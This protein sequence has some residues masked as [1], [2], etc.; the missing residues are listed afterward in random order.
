MAA[1]ADTYKTA[2]LLCLVPWQGCWE[3]GST[4][5]LPLSLPMVAVGWR[6]DPENVKAEDARSC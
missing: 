4:L 1:G 5:S 6:L 3:A 2:S